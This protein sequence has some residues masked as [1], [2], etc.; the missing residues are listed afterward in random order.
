MCAAHKLLSNPE[1]IRAHNQLLFALYPCFK[2][3]TGR[4]SSDKGCFELVDHNDLVPPLRTIGTFPSHMNNPSAVS[5]C[6]LPDNV[7]IKTKVTAIH[8]FALY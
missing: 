1:Q 7:F 5:E 8:Y 2:A 6:M 4:S 3:K